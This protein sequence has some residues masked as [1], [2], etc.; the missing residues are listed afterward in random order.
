MK[1]DRARSSRQ[2]NRVHTISSTSTPTA[3]SQSVGRQEKGRA[4]KSRSSGTQGL[5]TQVEILLTPIISRM[6]WVKWEVA[7]VG[8]GELATFALK[9]RPSSQGALASGS[10]A[11]DP[12]S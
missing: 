9:I 12:H 3:P 2:T 6:V 7:V 8:G 11:L 10:A 4:I 1:T 5:A